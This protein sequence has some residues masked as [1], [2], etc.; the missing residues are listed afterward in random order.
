MFSKGLA[1]TLASCLTLSALA[2][3]RRAEAGSPQSRTFKSV[4]VQVIRAADHD[5]LESILGKRVV[6]DVYIRYTTKLIIP[7][8]ERCWI[9]DED[10]RRG[11]DEKTEI[12]P[13]GAQ[14]VYECI[15]LHDQNLT[16][17]KPAYE[18]LVERVRQAT[19]WPSSSYSG[20]GWTTETRPYSHVLVP[21]RITVFHRPGDS[22]SRDVAE[23]NNTTWVKVWLFGSVSGW[24]VRLF[25]YAPWYLMSHAKK[26]EA[27][28]AEQARITAE[29]ARITAEHKSDIQSSRT[30]GY[31][32]SSGLM[33]SV[34]DVVGDMSQE[35]AV[36][37]CH[38]LLLNGRS[39]WRLPEIEEAEGVAAE[40]PIISD[41]AVSSVPIS[42]RLA[43]RIWTASKQPSGQPWVV[44]VFWLRR[45]AGIHDVGRVLCV[46]SIGD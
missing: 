23:V 40:H 35:A 8:F 43:T 3:T 30:K 21:D 14:L 9:S 13:D 39:G 45:A 28:V 25:V 37:Y 12:T 46:R 31:F 27:E 42:V 5:H 19:E 7:G 36:S 41:W 17:L 32:A 29:Q 1:L 10:P 34:T 33:W 44:N 38:D 6:D 20:A 24:D 18:R 22:A 26:L 4:L 15:L 2:Q 11:P 16:A